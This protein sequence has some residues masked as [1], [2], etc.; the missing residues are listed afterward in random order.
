MSE[1]D[2]LN[3]DSELDNDKDEYEGHELEEMSFLQ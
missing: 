2:F 1:D 3:L